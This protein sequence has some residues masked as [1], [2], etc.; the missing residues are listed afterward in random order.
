MNAIQVTR[1]GGPE[2]LGYGPRPDPAPAAGE[3][4]VRVEAA[5]VNYVDVY[6]RDGRYRTPLPF[7]PG[8]EGAGE[9]FA[10]AAGGEI[11]FHIDFE[12]PLSEAAEAH[13]RLQGRASSGKLLL[14]P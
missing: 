3:L 8:S 14:V 11:E 13:R 5:G 4:L 12:R 1:Y 9:V 2:V 10:W 7:V 6:Q